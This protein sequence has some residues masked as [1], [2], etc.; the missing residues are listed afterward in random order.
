VAEADPSTVAVWVAV[1]AVGVTSLW[2]MTSAFGDAKRV[3]DRRD[4][5]EREAAE[6]EAAAA[7]KKK[8]RIKD[9]FERL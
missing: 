8:Q 5:A 9:M 2:A 6:E 1:A 4:D 3:I 7:A